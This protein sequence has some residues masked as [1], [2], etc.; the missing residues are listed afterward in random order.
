MAFGAELTQEAVDNIVS[1]GK[2]EVEAY[3]AGAAM[4]LGL[5]QITSAPEIDLNESIRLLLEA[6]DDA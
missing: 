5:D 1:A 3:V 6:R 4:R 2:A